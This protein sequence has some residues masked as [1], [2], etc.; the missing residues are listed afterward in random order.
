MRR[1]RATTFTF[2]AGCPQIIPK[3]RDDPGNGERGSVV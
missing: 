3:L 1:K 2:P